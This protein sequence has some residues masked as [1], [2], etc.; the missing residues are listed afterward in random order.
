MSDG[1]SV[2][3]SAQGITCAQIPGNLVNTVRYS[4][5]ECSSIQR[6]PLDVPEDWDGVYGYDYG[7]ESW[8]QHLSMGRHAMI[9]ILY[10][11][12]T[13]TRPGQHFA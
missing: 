7:V 1:A 11:T 5:K 6:K 2:P 13:S 9:A 10:C 3:G 12:C 8:M 4:V